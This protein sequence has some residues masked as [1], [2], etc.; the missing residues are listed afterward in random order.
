VHFLAA[1]KRIGE[2]STKG[3]YQTTCYPRCGAVTYFRLDE[4]R[5]FS[6]SDRIYERGYA[7]PG[8][9]ELAPAKNPGWNGLEVIKRTNGAPRVGVD[10]YSL[11]G[12]SHR[13]VLT[14]GKR[15]ASG[16]ARHMQ[17]EQYTI[18][19]RIREFERTF[20]QRYGRRMTQDE[21][22]ILKAAQQIIQQKLVAK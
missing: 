19:D 1:L 4:L 15:N 5:A 10:H 7:E 16:A 17:D 6:I 18:L 20:E 11:Q 22:R 9:Y 14:Y 8:E 21:L 2:T 3:V 12:I 13:D